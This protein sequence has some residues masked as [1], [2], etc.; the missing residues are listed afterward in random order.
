MKTTGAHQIKV[1]NKLALTT[2]NQPA[3]PLTSG[4]HMSVQDWAVLLIKIAQRP[5]IPTILF[6]PAAKGVLV[7]VQCNAP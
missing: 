4:Y 2:T 1:P 6:S 5:R 3:L 7:L